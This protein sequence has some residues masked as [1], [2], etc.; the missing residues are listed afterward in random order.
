[1][2]CQDAN[3]VPFNADETLTASI[4]VQFLF[5]YIQSLFPADVRIALFPQGTLVVFIYNDKFT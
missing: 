4:R 5:G 1:M 3:A 2:K